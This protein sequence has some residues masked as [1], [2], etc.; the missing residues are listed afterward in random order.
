MSLPDTFEVKHPTKPLSSI[1]WGER[2]EEIR[3]KEDVDA[4]RPLPFDIDLLSADGHPLRFPLICPHCAFTYWV[5]PNEAFGHD[6]RAECHITLREEIYE[7]R[8]NKGS[9]WWRALVEDAT[10]AAPDSVEPE[11]VRMGEGE[12]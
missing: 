9:Q 11:A 7:E 8:E 2:K 1:T 10:K 12:G 5:A 4:I 3:L 6:M